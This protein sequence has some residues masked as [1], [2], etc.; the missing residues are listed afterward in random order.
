MLEDKS[1]PVGENSLEKTYRDWFDILSALS[2]SFFLQGQPDAS[3]HEKKQILETEPI[4]YSEYQDKMHRA[5]FEEKHE[6]GDLLLNKGDTWYK[7][8]GFGFSTEN[9]IVTFQR[10][11][12]LEQ[13]GEQIRKTGGFLSQEH[14]HPKQ[15]TVALSPPSIEDYMH[16][17]KIGMYTPT[18]QGVVYDRCGHWTIRLKL[19]NLFTTFHSEYATRIESVIRVQKQNERDQSIRDITQELSN[20]YNK[21][22]L[23]TVEHYLTTAQNVLKDGTLVNNAPRLQSQADAVGEILAP[24]GVETTYKITNISCD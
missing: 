16:V 21:D 1:I 9:R 2:V 4:S 14:T 10:I 23:A 8:S 17:G 18:V 5:V 13:L 7:I 20:R 6:Q 22:I 19:D 11:D 3:A 12:G 24:F 15:G